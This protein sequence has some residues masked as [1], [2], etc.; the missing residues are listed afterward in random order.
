MNYFTEILK[1]IKEQ[2]KRSP[3]ES[4]YDILG[5]LINLIGERDFNVK[6]NV[7]FLRDENTFE[8]NFYDFHKSMRQTDFY[9]LGEGHLDMIFW[10]FI[11]ISEIPEYAFKTFVN[12]LKEKTN[13]NEN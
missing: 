10:H 6:F 9:N 8:E 2:S 7:Y 13:D 5:H 11:H 3:K 4:E 12:S 1:H